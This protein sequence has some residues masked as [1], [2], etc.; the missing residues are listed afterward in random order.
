MSRSVLEVMSRSI[1]SGTWLPAGG[2]WKSAPASELLR[3][4][5]SWAGGQISS[6]RNSGGGAQQSAL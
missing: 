2:P 4:A 6:V 3:N 1:T 5:D